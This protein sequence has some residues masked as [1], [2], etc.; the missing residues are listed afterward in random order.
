MAARRSVC[1]TDRNR[2][3]PATDA[4]WNSSAPQRPPRERNMPALTL[5]AADKNDL[6][7]DPTDRL[8]GL[9]GDATLIVEQGDMRV[10]RPRFAP[11]DSG[12]AQRRDE[13][14]LK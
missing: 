12:F 4:G 9:I 5:Q 1:L 3:L 8:H 13:L 6:P 11:P 10:V 14:T 7:H 2:F